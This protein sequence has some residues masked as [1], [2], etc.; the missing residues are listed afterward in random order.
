MVRVLFAF[1]LCSFLTLDA[2]AQASRVQIGDGRVVVDGRAVDPASLPHSFDATGIKADILLQPETRA[3]LAIDGRMF[4]VDAEGIHEVSLTEAGQ[5][6]EPGRQARP[7]VVRVA[8]DRG[9]ANNID[10]IME[11][12]D[13]LHQRARELQQLT[14]ELQQTRAQ[15]SQLFEMIES[16][17]RSAAE[18]EEVARTLPHIH[19]QRYMREMQEHNAELYERLVREQVLERET[20]ELSQRIRDTADA[21][22]REAL[23]ERLRGRLDEIFEMKQENRRQEIAELER[24]LA[25]LQ[26][27]LEKRERHRDYIIQR[28]LNELIGGE[29]EG[30]Q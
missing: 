11:R 21:G 13:V 12:A 2:A 29:T 30:R 5:L 16:I 6:P 22:D 7:P 25:S 10:F 28:R 1:I 27:R 23:T 4:A 24:R 3:F 19:T 17:Q 8:S 15:S 20:L 26:R 14:L 9:D 18:T